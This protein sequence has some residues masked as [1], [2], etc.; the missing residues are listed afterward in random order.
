[1]KRLLVSCVLGSLLSAS[2]GQASTLTYDFDDLSGSGTHPGVELNGQDGWVVRQGNGHGFVYTGMSGQ[3]YFSGN[4]AY[5]PNAMHADRIVGPLV[6]AT[7]TWMALEFDGR[8]GSSAVRWSRFGLSYVEGTSPTDAFL[9]GCQ[10][11][12]WAVIATDVTVYKDATGMI[13]NG[14]ARMKLEVDLT[15]GLADFYYDVGGGYVAAPALQD[16]DL[17]LDLTRTATD[18]TNPENWNALYLRGIGAGDSW[19]NLRVEVTP[20]PATLSLLALGALALLRRRR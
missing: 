5:T 18:H 11:T 19:D 16:V 1:M 12:Q 6:T 8:V 7:D 13:A 9:F 15:T 20:E 4:H 14:P 10:G 17:K 2:A 3:G